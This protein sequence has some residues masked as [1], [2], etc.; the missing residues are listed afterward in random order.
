L[1]TTAWLAALAQQIALLKLSAKVTASML[2]ML[3]LASNAVLVQ[4][5]A[6]L[7]LSA[8]HN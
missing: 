6:P 7:K 1:V 8:K 4:V 2:S 5:H 3:T